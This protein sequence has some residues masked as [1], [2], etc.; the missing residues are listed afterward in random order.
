MFTAVRGER[1]RACATARPGKG[2]NT[3]LRASRTVESAGYLRSQA[4][5]APNRYRT[6]LGP[7]EPAAWRPKRDRSGP[8]LMQDEGQ[9]NGVVVVVGALALPGKA[10]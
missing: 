9:C 5:R 10:T 8:G 1:T 3:V 7:P 2:G 4:V 6:S